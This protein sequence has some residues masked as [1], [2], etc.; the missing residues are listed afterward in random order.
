MFAVT[1][2]TKE[3]VTM[4]NVNQVYLPHH[5]KSARSCRLLREPVN[6]TGTDPDSHDLALYRDQGFCSV[7]E[8]SV[9]FENQARGCVVSPQHQLPLHL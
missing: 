8:A 4:L 5:L 2:L 6:S 1:A 3:H 9:G 7:Y